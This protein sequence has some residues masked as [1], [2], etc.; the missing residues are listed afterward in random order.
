MQSTIMSETL[1]ES[2]HQ[3]L[4]DL[5]QAICDKISGDEDVA[6]LNEL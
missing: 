6:A 5:G 4:S 3:F 2:Y 1:G